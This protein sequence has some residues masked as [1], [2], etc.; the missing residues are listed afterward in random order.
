M[1]LSFHLDGTNGIHHWFEPSGLASKEGMG[2]RPAIQIVLHLSSLSSN[3][4]SCCAVNVLTQCF[5]QPFIHCLLF[6][7]LAHLLYSPR[8][9]LTVLLI[10]FSDMPCAP[11]FI[12]IK[13]NA[14]TV[15]D[16]QWRGASLKLQCTES[17]G[18]TTLTIKASICG[19][20][21]DT[22]KEMAMD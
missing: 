1:P 7:S 15:F 5:W 17:A 22:D 8:I 6:L 20:T 21:K 19:T 2:I 12:T 3:S 13:L 9:W 18:T 10:W 4:K 11:S 14:N 16:R